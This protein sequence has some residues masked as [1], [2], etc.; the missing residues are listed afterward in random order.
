M[1]TRGVSATVMGLLGDGVARIEGS[2]LP[3][4]R[5]DA[6]RLL[7]RLLGTTR[8]ALY[9][10]RD[11]RVDSEI[12]ERYQ[13]LVERRVGHEPL[14]YLLGEDEF[15]GVSLVVRPGVFIPRP[16]TEL[17]VE[18]VLA[19]LPPVSR[20][21]RRGVDLGTGTGCVA[22]ALSHA[23]ADLV[24]I[25]VDWSPNAVVLARENAGRLG[26]TGRV[27][28]REGNLWE[29]IPDFEGRLNLVVSNPPYIARELLK[30]L[31]EEVR[32]HEP[33]LA[34]DGGPGGTTLHERIIRDAPVFL[35]PG[36]L[37]ALE[38]GAGQAERLRALVQETGAFIDMALV[39]D[40]LGIER[41]LTARRR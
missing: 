4:A 14:Q 26:L 19:A 1:K 18:R 33:R 29:P 36:G 20:T 39:P 38:L 5:H 31:P 24:M 21:E 37:L 32:D 12:V 15:A 9:L 6:E 30:E 41:V 7:A 11:R 13:A 10:E 28:V 25:A 27:E 40:V 16:E 35:K 3:T 17:L 34:L 22:L 8:L 2:G 23:R